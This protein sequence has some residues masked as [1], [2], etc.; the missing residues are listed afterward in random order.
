MVF[1]NIEY[2]EKEE[3]WI[4]CTKNRVLVLDFF[5]FKTLKQEKIENIS[6]L[7]IDQIRNRVILS[8]KDQSFIEIDMNL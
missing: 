7:K 4:A 5:E 2:S 3:V 8:L 1:K 6:G